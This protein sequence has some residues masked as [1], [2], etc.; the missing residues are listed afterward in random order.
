MTR[1]WKA[2]SL[3]P[4]L[5]CGIPSAV[6]QVAPGPVANHAQAT[7]EIGALSAT[8]AKFNAYVTYMNQ[9]SGA[10]S[11]LARYRSWVDMKRGPNGRE[12]RISG[13]GSASDGGQQRVAAI[14]AAAAQPPL[15]DLDEAMRAYIAADDVLVPVLNEA[16]GYYAREDY[17]LDAMAGGKKL[18]ARIAAAAGPYLA[19]RERLER[20]MRVEKEQLDAIS[21][22]TIEKR[23]GRSVSWHVLDV[24][25]RS[26]QLLDRLDSETVDVPSFD[27]AL[28]LVAMAIT[29]MD[30]FAVGHPEAS[31]TTGMNDEFLADARRLR[32]RLAAVRG[33]IR[34][35]DPMQLSLLRTH[36]DSMLML[37]RPAPVIGR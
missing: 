18:H 34:R 30:A 25:T 13:V 12:H 28:Q 19:A 20:V 10:S 29:D 3:V 9:T 26:K 7:S 4:C 33:D 6:G 23:E 2:A 24:T 11:A 16:N 5:L 36:Y 37:I 31:L 14:A 32:S 17:K 22:A 1:N 27:A 15:P 35:V 8:T 21:L